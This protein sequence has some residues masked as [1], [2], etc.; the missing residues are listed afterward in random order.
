MTAL[1][2]VPTGR[3]TVR[4]AALA[5]VPWLIPQARA[6]AE[7]MGSTVPIWPGDEH[8]AEFL[9]QFIEHQ[10][11]FVAEME[12]GEGVGFIMGMLTPHY[13]NGAIITLTELAW[14]VAPEHRGSRAGLYLLEAFSDYGREVATWTTL[15]LEENSPIHDRTM[16]KRGFHRVERVYLREEAR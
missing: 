5:D 6:F 14:W 8:A 4:R 11:V 7:S 13:F 16:E 9:A 3:V 10:H 12:D 2:L 15:S 1:A